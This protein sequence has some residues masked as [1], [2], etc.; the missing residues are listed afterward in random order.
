MTG[1]PEKIYVDEVIGPPM[2]AYDRDLDAVVV[3]VAIRSGDGN[4]ILVMTPDI[5]ETLSA[6]LG[7]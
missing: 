2:K 3:A 1:R 4:A 5:A 7:A 6:G